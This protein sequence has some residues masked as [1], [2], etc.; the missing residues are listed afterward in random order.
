M[1]HVDDFSGQKENPRLTEPQMNEIL[2]AE[3]RKRDPEYKQRM[4]VTVQKSLTPP[5]SSCF[6][7]S[8]ASSC[9]TNHSDLDSTFRAPSFNRNEADYWPVYEKS[10][11]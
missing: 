7:A 5:D 1:Q 2:P 11:Q 10:T 8:T 6:T 9:E 3:E 4:T